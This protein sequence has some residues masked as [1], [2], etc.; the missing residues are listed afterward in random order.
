MRNRSSSGCSGIPSSTAHQG[1]TTSCIHIPTHTHT[2]I[3]THTNPHRHTYMLPESLRIPSNCDW[4]SARCCGGVLSAYNAFSNW[5][6][7]GSVTMPGRGM[8]EARA[9][10]PAGRGVEAARGPGAGGERG[11]G[12]W[13]QGGTHLPDRPRTT[14]TTGTCSQ[15]RTGRNDRCHQSAASADKAVGD[16]RYTSPSPTPAR[17]PP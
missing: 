13:G 6:T 3:D 5:T 8:P 14:T 2:H 11:S 15:G 1:L 12:E 4:I 7:W 17:N 9:G 10:T 16:A